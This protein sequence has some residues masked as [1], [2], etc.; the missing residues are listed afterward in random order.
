[1][2]VGIRGALSAAVP[3]LPALL[4][5]KLVLSVRLSA[6]VAISACGSGT[7]NKHFLGAGFYPGSTHSSV[8]VPPLPQLLPRLNELLYRTSGGE[9]LIV[10]AAFSVGF[11]I[12]IFDVRHTQQGQSTLQFFQIVF[13]EGFVFR[14]VGPACHDEGF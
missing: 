10:E 8:M 3:T 5:W 11:A 1:M 14:E 7:S 12:E 2:G 4:R 9:S 6:V 13:G